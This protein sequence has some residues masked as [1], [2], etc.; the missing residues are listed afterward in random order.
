MGYKCSQGAIVKINGSYFTKVNKDS[1]NIVSCDV[2]SV[3][4]NIR[5]Y[6][7][8]VLVKEANIYIISYLKLNLMTIFQNT[9]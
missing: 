3:L 6:E 2:N 7:L 4:A 9:Y 5:L 8:K 1:L